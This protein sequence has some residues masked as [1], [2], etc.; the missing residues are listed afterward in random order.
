MVLIW[1]F[2]DKIFLKK[3]IWVSFNLHADVTPCQKIRNVSCID[4][5]ENLRN[6]I[7]GPF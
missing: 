1:K 3:I 2:Q 4:F 5:L 7:L 6:L